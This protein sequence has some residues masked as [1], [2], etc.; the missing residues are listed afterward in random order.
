LGVWTKYLR[1]VVSGRQVDEE[2]TDDI[3]TA[4]TRGGGDMVGEWE[5]EVEV[6]VMG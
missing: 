4:S 3:V 5:W 1:K 6:G 2:G